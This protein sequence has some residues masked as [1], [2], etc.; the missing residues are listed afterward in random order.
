MAADR[1]IPNGRWRCQRC[2][3]QWEHEPRP[4]QCPSCGAIDRIDWLNWPQVQAAVA[5]EASRG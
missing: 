4:T 2:L 1:M 3:A 5:K